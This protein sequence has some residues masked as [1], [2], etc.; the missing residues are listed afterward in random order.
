MRKIKFKDI[1]NFLEGNSNLIKDELG[2]LSEHYKEQIAYRR[3]QCEDCW[4]ERKCQHCKCSLPG[5]WYTIQTCNN[6]ERFPD[7]MDKE[8]WDKY[9]LD[10]GI[11]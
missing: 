1:T 8:D 7:L 10:N 11:N 4:E 5:R 9:K 6:G 2:I 3:L